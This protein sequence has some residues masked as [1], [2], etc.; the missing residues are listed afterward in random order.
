MI[1]PFSCDRLL[2]EFLQQR[3]YQTEIYTS[4]LPEDFLRHHGDGDLTT[5]SNLKNE[6][7]KIA[8]L[9]QI[10]FV[11][12]GGQGCHSNETQYHS[13]LGR[14]DVLRVK[15]GDTSLSTNNYI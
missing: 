13:V 1:I 8:P 10:V 6:Q 2:V 3:Q 7:D 4:I 12:C 9:R 5:T 11:V 14:L 15:F